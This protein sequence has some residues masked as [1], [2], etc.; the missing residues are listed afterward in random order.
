MIKL[1]YI[2]EDEAFQN[3]FYHSF[4][5]TYEVILYEINAQ[6]SIESLVGK[7]E[8]DNLGM[9][10]VDYNLVETGLV[11]FNGD[12]IINNIQ[13]ILSKLPLMILTS[14]E[15]DALNFIS[16]GSLV[17]SKEEFTSNGKIFQH[18]VQNTITNYTDEIKRNKALIKKLNDKKQSLE[19]TEREE[20]A[21]FKSYIYLN[22]V[23]PQ[24]KAISDYLTHPSKLK[25][26]I[27]LLHESNT[28]VTQLKNS[29]NDPMLNNETF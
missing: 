4:N 21:L 1:G 20:D 29:S 13:T 5:E 28:L 11:N 7:I 16:N 2:D 17:Y 19:L 15:E 3:T 14:D 22:E 6:T 18:K 12:A 23:Y 24:D 26:L 10:I 25:E 27:S 8:N 9:L